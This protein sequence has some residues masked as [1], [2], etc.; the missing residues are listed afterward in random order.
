MEEEAERLCE[1]E[2]MEDSKEARPPSKHRRPDATVSSQRL[3]QQAQGPHS[4][5]SDVVPVQRGS[6][7]KA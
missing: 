7:H 3:W 2:G 4:S 1:P 6:G 5:K